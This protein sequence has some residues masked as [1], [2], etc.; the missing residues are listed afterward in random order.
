MFDIIFII[1]GVNLATLILSVLII[2]I[3]LGGHFKRK[4]VEREIIKELQKEKWEEL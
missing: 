1:L 4:A 2:G 3:L